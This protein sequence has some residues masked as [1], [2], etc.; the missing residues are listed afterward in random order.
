MR[1]LVKL[2]VCL[3]AWTLSAG[4]RQLARPSAPVPTTTPAVV[5]SKEVLAEAGLE[6]YWCFRLKLN[7]GERIDQLYRVDGNFYCVT[8]Q[9]RLVA[10]DA[11]RGV[12]KWAYTIGRKGESIFRPVHHD[13]VALRDDRDGL[14]EMLHPKQAK[15]AP[16]F[17]AV[18]INTVSSLIVLDRATGRQVRIIELGFAANTGGATDGTNFYMGST[19]G[20]YHAV[21]MDAEVGF[22]TMSTDDVITAPVEYF[23]NV[24]YVGSQDKS[25][26]A[27]AGRLHRKLLWRRDF[28]APIVAQFH[29]DRRGCFVGT[30]NGEIFVLD[31]TTG[32][33]LKIP[34]KEIKA[35]KDW[36]PFV[37]NGQIRDPI[38]LTANTILQ[39]ARKDKFYAIGLR[40]G[41]L[42]W[43][44]PHGRVVLAVIGRNVYL[45]DK[46]RTLLVVDEITGKV[47]PSA[48]MRGWEVF[49][50]NTTLAAIYAA[51][52]DGMLS[53]IRP[54]GSG[55]LTA[56][57]LNPR[58]TPKP[59]PA[60]PPP[61]KPAPAKPPPPKPAASR[62]AKE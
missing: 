11:Q 33:Q 1:G 57:M 20:Y 60:K 46:N 55:H 4:C 34:D 45:L 7:A 41:E 49:V 53:C 22:W 3:V 28:A 2:V 37:C 9:R 12:P 14:L 24:V 48:P 56:K 13:S 52:P 50:P 47:G 25:M 26:C 23:D 15:P 54:K 29:V 40:T 30:L 31:R 36:G 5:V 62:P 17:D 39:R 19:N 44:H 32:E 38:Q 16:Q 35:L 6:Y 21:R 42:A 10:V 59:A 8:S 58:I 43:T 27:A 18:M 51:T 61:P